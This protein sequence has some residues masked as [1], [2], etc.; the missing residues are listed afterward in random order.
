VVGDQSEDDHLLPP[1][2]HLLLLL[3]PGRQH[4]GR[5]FLRIR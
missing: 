5:S 1:A 2:P 4:L 3:L